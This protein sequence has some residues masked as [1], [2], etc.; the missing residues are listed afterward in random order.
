[1]STTAGGPCPTPG[2][3]SHRR[4]GQYLCLTCWRRLTDTTRRALT[5]RDAQVYLRLQELH[6]QLTARTPLHK[7]EVT[8]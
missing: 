1:M 4:H 3:Q 7:I 2:C 8:P 5:R 6:R